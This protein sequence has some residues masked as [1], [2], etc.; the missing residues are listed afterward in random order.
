MEHVSNS[1]EETEELGATLA[2]R[3]SAGHG[4]CI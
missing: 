4:R 3:L 2:G 1:P